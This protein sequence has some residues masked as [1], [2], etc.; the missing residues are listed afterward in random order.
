MPGRTIIGYAIRAGKHS[1]R[2]I[3]HARAMRAHIGA[4]I[5][6]ELVIDRQNAAVA[7][8]GGANFVP[9]LPRMIGGDEMLVTILDPLHRVP[10]TQSAE[11]DQHVFGVKLAA[12]AE[13]AADMA[14]EQMHGRERSAENFRDQLART[15]RDL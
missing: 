10:E 1:R 8:D 6:K 11:A 5:V 13:A 7:I 4:L 15:V 3:D 9:L 2:E 14:F 12:H